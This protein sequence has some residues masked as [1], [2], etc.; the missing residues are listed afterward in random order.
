MKKIL[1]QIPKTIDDIFGQFGAT[2]HHAANQLRWYFAALFL[3][4][5]LW[6]WSD[7]S[8]AKFIYPV[9][10]LLWLMTAFLWGRRPN[11][12][13]VNNFSLWVDVAIL[14][15]GL[16]LCAWQGVF[17]TKGWLVFLCYF[18]VLA[19]TARRYNFLLV[20]QVAAFLVAFYAL[21]SLFAIGSLAL[22]RLLVIGALDLAAHALN[23]QMIVHTLTLHLLAI[24]HR[25]A[26]LVQTVQMALDVHVILPNLDQS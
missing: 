25:A 6:N 23:V 8:A 12:N 14:S 15:L 2:A 26:L 3:V 21:V 22:P 18:P 9:L 11:R 1:A 20:L 7:D 13:P 16:L 5:T 17:N 24:V 19:L 10:A 4:A